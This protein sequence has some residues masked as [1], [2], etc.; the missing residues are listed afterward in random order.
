MPRFLISVLIVY[1]SKAMH[2]N[3]RKW[4]NELFLFQEEY[5]YFNF[6]VKMSDQNNYLNYWNVTNIST[7]DLFHKMQRK[8]ELLRCASDTNKNAWG[9]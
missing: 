9:I 2:A 8:K 5:N 6:W 1:L 3:L 4:M 7:R